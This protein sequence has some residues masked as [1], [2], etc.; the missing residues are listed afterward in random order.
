MEDSLNENKTKIIIIIIQ[1]SK[2]GI[3]TKADWQRGGC[4]QVPP[5]LSPASRPLA[6][7][8]FFSTPTPTPVQPRREAPPR[9]EACHPHQTGGGGGA[10]VCLCFVYSPTRA[11]ISWPPARFFLSTSHSSFRQSLPPYL[12]YFPAFSV[13]RHLSHQAP[14]RVSVTVSPYLMPRRLSKHDAPHFV[15]IPNRR[16][17]KINKIDK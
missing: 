4:V 7:V 15:T 16:K 5:R 11:V 3:S 10:C 17:R 6:D 13:N 1:N 12:L 9:R 2:G 8:A 14:K